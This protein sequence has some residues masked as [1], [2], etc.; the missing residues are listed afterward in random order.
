MNCI[1]EQIERIKNN[2][3]KRYCL[4]DC[5]LDDNKYQCTTFAIEALTK[6]GISLPYTP[7]DWIEPADLL[8][9]PGVNPAV[10]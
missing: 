10:Y 7:G 1:N 6:C 9:W 8:P 4:S 2:K 3:R 5:S